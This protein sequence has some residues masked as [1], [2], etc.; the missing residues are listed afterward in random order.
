MR[1]KATTTQRRHLEAESLREW[2]ELQ[3]ALPA[4]QELVDAVG[5]AALGELKGFACHHGLDFRGCIRA[6]L[7]ALDAIAEAEPKQLQKI[8]GIGAQKAAKLI[9]AART[10]VAWRE[11]S[12][13]W[14][15]EGWSEERDLARATGARGEPSERSPRSRYVAFQR[16]R[17]LGRLVYFTQWA[18]AWKAAY[19][20]GGAP[21]F[22]DLTDGEAALSLSAQEA[23]ERIQ[24]ELQKV[25]PGVNLDALGLSVRALTEA[26]LDYRKRLGIGKR[27]STST[28][29]AST[30]TA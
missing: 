10:E 7:V 12:R 9:E 4:V 29:R 11:E 8:K 3:R 2:E 18:P 22:D 19:D 30:P 20:R 15:L 25:A 13:R 14:V 1:G 16:E 28:S 6:G 27:D 23:A 24:A 5:G 26:S 17:M 21:P